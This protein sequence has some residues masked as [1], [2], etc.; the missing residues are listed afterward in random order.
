MYRDLKYK[1]ID[2]VYEYENKSIQNSLEEDKTLVYDRYVT[3]L[4]NE[5]KQ[6]EEN[7]NKYLLEYNWYQMTVNGAMLNTICCSANND[8]V[9][10]ENLQP[11]QVFNN[12][13]INCNDSHMTPGM[14][15]GTPYIVHSL[16]DHDI[17][18]DLFEI[19]KFKKL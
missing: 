5:M 19:K 3:K 11:N 8:F 10:D 9:N 17:L 12:S 13:K 2:H 6:L 4:E 16:H 14:L 7:R 15:I 18:E 1:N